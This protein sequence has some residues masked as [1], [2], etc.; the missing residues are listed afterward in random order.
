MNI[1]FD[2]GNIEAIKNNNIVL[3]LD[4]FY[5]KQLDKTTTAYCVID[6]IKLTDFDKIDHNQTLHANAI[7]A[8]KNQEFKLCQDLLAHLSGAFNGELDSFYSELNQRIQKLLDNPVDNWT[9]IV[10]KSE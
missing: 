9:S 1:I 2:T 10:I 7:A 6:N 3:E 4:T 5:L 8:Y